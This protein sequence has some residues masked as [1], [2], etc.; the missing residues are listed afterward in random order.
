MSQN[1]S[2]AYY[3][4]ARH[5]FKEQGR[6]SKQPLFRNSAEGWTPR[7]EG[8]ILKKE[9]VGT[10]NEAQRGAYREACVARAQAL[11]GAGFPGGVWERG[12]W[13]PQDWPF[14][15]AAS[16]YRGEIGGYEVVR[17][18]RAWRGRPTAWAVRIADIGFSCS[19]ASTAR[20]YMGQHG[21][22]YVGGLWHDWVERV[23][24]SWI[25][26]DKPP[27]LAVAEQMVNDALRGLL[28]ANPD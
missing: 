28:L 14:S 11:I 26:F 10:L 1:D 12:W 3:S 20:A 17:V 8:R 24:V 7:H 23:S 15:K 27:H 25:W 22:V 5:I 13:R 18:A 4:S 21:P 9:G 6:D 19:D 16:R 2:V